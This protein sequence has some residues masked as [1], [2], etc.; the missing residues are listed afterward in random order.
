[1]NNYQAMLAY[2][3][4]MALQQKNM[5]IRNNY[6]L[7]LQYCQ[8]N[9][10]VVD[11]PN[12]I[13]FFCQYYQYYQSQLQK[14]RQQQVI[15]PQQIFRQQ[16]Q[17]YPQQQYQQPQQQ[18]Q[19]SFINNPPY[20]PGNNLQQL[21]PRSDETLY[22]NAELANLPNMINII[23]KATSGLNVVVIVNKNWPMHD[24]FKLYMVN[25]Y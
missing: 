20:L 9:G 22:I 12:S 24:M 4:M 23:F 7:Y 14:Q 5:I 13:N 25:L 6:P 3:Q 19:Q 8:V 2:Q 10:L 18:S 11:H 15:Q 21:I 17:Q 1:M 16:P